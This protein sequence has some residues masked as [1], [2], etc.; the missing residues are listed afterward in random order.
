MPSP[1]FYYNKYLFSLVLLVLAIGDLGVKKKVQLNA[2]Y[3]SDFDSKCQMMGSCSKKEVV[4][5][6]R[7]TLLSV[8]MFC[9]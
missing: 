1:F 4:P 2:I 8:G 7:S 5:G 3:T 9:K 6:R